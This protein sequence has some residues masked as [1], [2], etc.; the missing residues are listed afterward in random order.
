MINQYARR[1]HN[2]HIP[3]SLKGSE[4]LTYIPGLGYRAL[5]FKNHSLKVMNKTQETGKTTVVKNFRYFAAVY[6]S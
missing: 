3:S 4:Q 5:G 1:G 2:A 6:F